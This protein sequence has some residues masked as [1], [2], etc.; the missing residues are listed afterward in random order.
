MYIYIYIYILSL[1][2]FEICIE[3][4]L[5]DGFNVSTLLSLSKNTMH[6]IET[7][8]F[9]TAHANLFAQNY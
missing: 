1:D 6:A 4:Q 5:S 8:Q 9:S 7:I 3:L 2:K